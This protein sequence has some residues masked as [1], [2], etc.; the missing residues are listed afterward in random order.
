[1]A[2]E[3]VLHEICTEEKCEYYRREPDGYTYCLH[4]KDVEEFEKS[5]AEAAYDAFHKDT[6]AVW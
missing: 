5:E 1:M 6:D 4:E 2:C 3:Y